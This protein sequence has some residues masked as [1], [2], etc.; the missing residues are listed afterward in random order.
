[1]AGLKKK[2]KGALANPSAH[3]MTSAS[4]ARTEQMSTLDERFEKKLEKEYGEDGYA[5]DDNLSLAS[6]VTGVSKMFGM[7]NASRV[8][9][10]SA[11]SGISESSEAPPLR[12]DFD[13]IMDDFLGSHSK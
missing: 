9:R 13:S 8:S 11:L 5:G 3:S 7:S 2:R 6:G 1:M 4:L 12:S 10:F